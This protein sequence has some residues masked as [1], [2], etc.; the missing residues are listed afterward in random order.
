MKEKRE[1]TLVV[2]GGKEEKAPGSFLLQTLYLSHKMC[3]GK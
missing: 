1:V 3:V 2:I